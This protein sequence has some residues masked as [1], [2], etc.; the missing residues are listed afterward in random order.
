MQVWIEKLKVIVNDLK[1]KP[2]SILIN[3]IEVEGATPEAFQVANEYNLWLCEQKLMAKAIVTSAVQAE[4]D[5]AQI[6]GKN[7]NHQNYK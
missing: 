3:S 1:S 7:R 6:D 4:I 2:F 5:S